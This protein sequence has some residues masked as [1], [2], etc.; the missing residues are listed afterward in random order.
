MTIVTASSRIYNE[1]VQV[2]KKFVQRVSIG[3]DQSADALVGDIHAALFD[4]G[5][6]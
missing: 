5:D 3:R 2:I 6:R 1:A 4:M